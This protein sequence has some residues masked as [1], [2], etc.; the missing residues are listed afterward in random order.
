MI[1]LIII[2][3]DWEKKRE[4]CIQKAVIYDKDV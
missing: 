1:L 2:K 3:I 4:E